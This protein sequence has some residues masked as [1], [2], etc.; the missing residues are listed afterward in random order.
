MFASRPLFQSAFL[1]TGQKEGILVKTAPKQELP[2]PVELVAGL[3]LLI[4]AEREGGFPPAKRCLP[5][6]RQEIWEG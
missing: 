2:F 5:S 1:P 4:Q 3:A 6:W